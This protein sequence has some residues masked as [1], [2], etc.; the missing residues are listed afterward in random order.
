MASDDDTED[1]RRKAADTE[2]DAEAVDDNVG[3]PDDV[4][5]GPDAPA[6]PQIMTMAGAPPVAAGAP[7]QDMLRRHGMPGQEQGPGQGHGWGQGMGGGQ[8][9]SGWLQQLM[10]RIQQA[11]QAR[12]AQRGERMQQFAGSPMGQQ[13]MAGPMG[14]RM[15]QHHP[16]WFPGAPAT[17]A[18]PAGATPANIVEGDHTGEPGLPPTAAMAAQQQAAAPQAAAAPAPAAAPQRAMAPSRDRMPQPMQQ[19]RPQ[20][21][22]QRPTLGGAGANDAIAEALRRRNGGGMG[23]GRRMF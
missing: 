11:Q 6:D 23:G 9:H 17:P 22:M 14:Q 3:S 2:A 5:A 19:A 7:G 18:A 12:Q 15:Q 10:Q 16:D 21:Q 13:F 20:Q 4:I 8:G 1:K